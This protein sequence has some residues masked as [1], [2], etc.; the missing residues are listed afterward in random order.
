MIYKKPV[1]VPHI[2][3]VVRCKDCDYSMGITEKKCPISIL[4]PQ[5]GQ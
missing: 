1:K 3:E 5:F 4:A 2:H